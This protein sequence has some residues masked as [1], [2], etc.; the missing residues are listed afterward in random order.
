MAA[1][2]RLRS[3]A[4]IRIGPHKMAIHTVTVMDVEDAVAVIVHDVGR[5]LCFVLRSTAGN[6]SVSWSTIAPQSFFFVVFLLV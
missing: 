4:T 1:H 5:A 2:I 6:T 3:R